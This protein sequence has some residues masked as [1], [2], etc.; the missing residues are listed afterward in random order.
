MHK[1]TSLTTVALLASFMPVAQG[2]ELFNNDKSRL[3]FKGNLSVY[4]INS[5]ETAEINDG[6][7]RYTFSLSHQMKDNWQAVGLL[8]WGIQISN[9]AD[10]IYVGNNGLTSTGPTTDTTWLRLGYV[11]FEHETYG[12]FTMGKQWGVSFDVAGVTDHFEIFGADAQGTFNFGTDGGF[13]GSGRAEQAIQYKVNYQKF[14]FAAQYLVSDD[15]VRTSEIP[16]AEDAFGV[17]FNDSYGLAV[18]YQAPF[19][20][21]FGLAYNKAKISLIADIDKVNDYRQSAKADD[22]LITAHITYRPYGSL[23]LHVAVVFTD[24]TYHEVNDIGTVMAKSSGV[25]LFAAYRFDNNISVIVG[26]NSLTDDSPTSID[27]VSDYHLKYYILS[28]KYHWDENFYFYIESKI[29][30]SILVAA[31]S[32]QGENATGVGMMFVF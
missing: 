8:E 30:D 26:Y 12:R 11:G 9:T 25:E 2:L 3:D 24:M 4:Y 14:S 5:G 29:D 15:E 27:S 18:I 13:S 17:K 23:G 21:G 7:S 16:G 1:I 22:Q 10:H 28:A 31:G 6:F 20:L 32:N 19:D